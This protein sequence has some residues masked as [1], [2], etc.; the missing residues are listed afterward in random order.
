MILVV[1]PSCYNKTHEK[2]NDIV[3]H[4]LASTLADFPAIYEGDVVRLHRALIQD[5]L[6]N[7]KLDIRIFSEKDMVV[8]PL[9]E[10]K[11]PHSAAAHYAITVEDM[12]TVQRLL[13]WSLKCIKPNQQGMNQASGP[14]QA[15]RNDNVVTLA[16]R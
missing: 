4:I 2:I 3:L 11:E 16:V 5:S 9:D 8:F 1:D 13:P 10:R 14:V 7:N 15:R 12:K 6:Q